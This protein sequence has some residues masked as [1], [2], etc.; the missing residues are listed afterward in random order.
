MKKIYGEGVVSMLPSSRGFVFTTLQTESENDTKGVVSFRQ[1]NFD[2]GKT[3]LMTKSVYLLHKFG[4]QYES[5]IAGVE[6]YVYCRTV[7]LPDAR[8]LL[9]HIDGNACLLAA[10]GTV[11]W[12][13][14]LKYKGFAPSDT[15]GDGDAIWCAYPESN[16][17]IKYGVKLM[18][19]EFR[20][21]TGASGGIL[22]PTGL[23][24]SGDSLVMTSGADGV[25]K[26]IDLDDFHVETIAEFGEPVYQYLKIDSNEIIHAKSGIYR[27]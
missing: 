8:M 2:T 27:L 1:Y 9:V 12:E 5:F 26:S 25:I 7:Q 21:S 19:Q 24:Q 18:R 14:S 23:Y 3:E 10:D 20:I 11:K 17:V 15:I 6:D 13:G 4:N 22:E 16:A